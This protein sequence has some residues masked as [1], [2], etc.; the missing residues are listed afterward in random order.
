MIHKTKGIVLRTVKYGE[1]SVIVTILTELFGIQSYMVNG[2]RT[3]SRTSTAHF[4]Q[5]ASILDIQ[6]YHNELKNLQRIK[7]TR[8][9]HIYRHVLSDIIKNAV[10]MYMVELLQKC[11]KQPEQNID[12]FN[13]TEDALLALDTANEKVLANFP[14]YFSLQLAHFF[15]FRLTDNFSDV[16]KIFDLQEGN[17]IDSPPSHAYFV[18]AESGYFLSQLLKAFH[19]DE[20]E[21]ISGNRILRRNML[22]S[23]E[24]YYGL[25]V[26]D[27][28]V[29]KTL[30]V[31]FEILS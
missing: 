5:P 9:N 11:I 3:A 28:G 21:Q 18:D 20:L 1:T 2:V 25:H 26:Q 13:F 24:M 29:M 19:P 8:W 17:F 10:A 15:G 31:L 6:V 14:L 12:L 4:F 16:Q 27:F 7:E 23:I 22:S 30:P